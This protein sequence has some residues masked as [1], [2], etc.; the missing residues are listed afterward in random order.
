MTTT[1]VINLLESVGFDIKS[2]QNANASVYVVLSRLA[3]KGQISR[4]NNENAVTWKGPMFDPDTTT[5]HFR[6]DRHNLGDLQV[7]TDGPTEIDTPS[8]VSSDTS[9]ACGRWLRNRVHLVPLPR[10][11]QCLAYVRWRHLCGYAVARGLR[12]LARL[13]S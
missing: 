6:A 8:A 1:D 13:T 12:P 11:A 7:A 10:A 4:G 9:P 5:C 3:R 2:Q